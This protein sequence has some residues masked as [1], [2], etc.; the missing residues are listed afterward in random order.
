M[1]VAHAHGER[2]GMHVAVIDVPALL[3]FRIAAAG[4]FWDQS[5]NRALNHQANCLVL[6]VGVS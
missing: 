3:A 4:E 2:A 1:R 6:W 5:L